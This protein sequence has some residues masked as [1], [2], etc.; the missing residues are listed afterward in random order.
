[1][2]KLK[3]FTGPRSEHLTNG[4]D[5]KCNFLCLSE[6]KFL[7]CLYTAIDSHLNLRSKMENRNVTYILSE[8]SD[9][10]VSNLQKKLHWKW[11]VLSKLPVT[12]QNFPD[13][14]LKYSVSVQRSI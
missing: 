2:H 8:I 6:T 12:S 5:L 7:Y 13:Q 4:A 9:M 10:R 3:T 1:M 14:P 11:F